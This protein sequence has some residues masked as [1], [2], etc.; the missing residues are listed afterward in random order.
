M[1]L[2]DYST[3]SRGSGVADL[4]RY[5]AEIGFNVEVDGVYGPA[6][7]ATVTAFQRMRGI[8]ADGIAGPETLVALSQARAEGM[9][10]AAVPRA[11]ATSTAVPH[12]PASLSTPVQLAPA[13]LGGSIIPGLNLDPKKMKPLIILVVI[14]I[15]VWLWQRSGSEE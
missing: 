3:G 10:V 8:R 7:K 15:G 5:L 4:Q 1:A 13:G 2:G 14:A 11:G 9:R 6:T 12:D